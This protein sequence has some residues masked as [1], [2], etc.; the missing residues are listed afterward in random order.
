M[1]PQHIKDIDNDSAQFSK[2]NLESNNVDI[3]TNKISM[4]NNFNENFIFI[5]SYLQYSIFHYICM[6]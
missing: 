2:V 1:N 4:K 5:P 3:E 6:I